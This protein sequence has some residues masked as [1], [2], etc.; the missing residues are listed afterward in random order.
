MQFPPHT[1]N[2]KVSSKCQSKG[3]QSVAA[4]A[5]EGVRQYLALKEREDNP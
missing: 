4:N 2:L 1:G 5:S 3:L